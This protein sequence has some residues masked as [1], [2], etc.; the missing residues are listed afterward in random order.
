M[1]MNVFLF[2]CQHLYNIVV[3]PHWINSVIVDLLTDASLK[4]T[5][6]VPKSS[7]NP[8]PVL[9]PTVVKSIS[10]SPF[11]QELAALVSINSYDSTSVFSKMPIELSTDATFFS[12]KLEYCILNRFT[13]IIE[14]P[15]VALLIVD[16]KLYENL[17]L[18]V[19]EFYKLVHTTSRSATDKFH[20]FS[21]VKRRNQ[22]NTNNSESHDSRH[23]QLNPHV[24]NQEF[25]FVAS[26][27]WMEG[28]Q[29]KGFVCIALRVDDWSP[30]SGIIP[31]QDYVKPV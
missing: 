11:K 7:P 24:T 27:K 30:L 3:P 13:H 9:E 12:I 5:A 15:A 23:Q 26:K 2:V 16:K 1:T 29:S 17:N 8:V 19:N 25:M 22:P 31:S 10:I 21:A 14:S 20:G 4:T 28:Y 6:D 18:R